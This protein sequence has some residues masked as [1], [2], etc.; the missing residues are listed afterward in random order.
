MSVEL[1]LG[2]IGSITGVFS[3]LLQFLDFKSLVPKLRVT[4][5]KERSFFYT[6]EDQIIV[7]NNYLT[8]HFAAIAVQIENISST[9]ITIS[10][11]YLKENKKSFIKYPHA[12]DFKLKDPEVQIND[13]SRFILTLPNSLKLPFRIDRYD[14]IYLLLKFPFIP[15]CDAP[16]LF[17]ETPTK[18]YS[19]KAKL[20]SF[21]SYA[22]HYPFQ[23]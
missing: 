3:L 1:L 13:I 5:N 2:I 18:K 12:N 7:D 6:D 4:I 20:S 9:P 16:T 21:R 22:D 11:V 19:W 14:S 15:D 10:S 17:F 23:E 8:K